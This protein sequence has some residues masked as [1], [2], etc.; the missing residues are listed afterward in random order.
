MSGVC[1]DSLTTPWWQLF[2]MLHSIFMCVMHIH[3]VCLIGLN[4]CLSV[5]RYRLHR[6]TYTQPSDFP[7]DSFLDIHVFIHKYNCTCRDLYEIFSYR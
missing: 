7:Q 1:V 5:Y 2:V 3:V 6:I 4:I